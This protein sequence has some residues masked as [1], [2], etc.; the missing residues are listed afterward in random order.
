MKEG[1]A[2]KKILRCANKAMIINLGRYFLFVGATAQIA[3]RPPCLMFLDHTRTRCRRRCYLHNTQHTD[4]HVLSGI[5]KRDSSNETVADQHLR[6]GRCLG[7]VKYTRTSL[8]FNKHQLM[9]INF[10]HNSLF[11]NFH[12]TYFGGLN[13]HLQGVVKIIL[14]RPYT[15]VITVRSMQNNLVGRKGEKRNA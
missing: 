14:H 10:F 2:Y 5:R 3:S 15:Y 9:H 1:V 12:Y 11:L 7:K 4:I 13:H 8:M 6:T